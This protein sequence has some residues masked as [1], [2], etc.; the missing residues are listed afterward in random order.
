MTAKN[1][2][3]FT[4]DISIS[5]KTVFATDSP[6]QTRKI[7]QAFA[8]LLKKGDVVF[9]NGELGSGKTTFTQGAVK[10]FGNKGFARSSSFMLVTEY[11]AGA[12]EKLFHIDLYRLEPSYIEETGL[13]E[14]ICGDGIALIEWPQ[15]LKEGGGLK[16][17]NIK[18]EYCGEE[19]RKITIE[20]SK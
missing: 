14:Y 5:E 6:E 10:A 15:R 12:G 17:W 1:V 8:A 4:A 13:E 2:K 7:G 18:F 20:K 9:L 16:T 11:E 3:R 19:K